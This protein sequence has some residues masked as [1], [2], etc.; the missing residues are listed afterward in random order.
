MAI[1]FYNAGDNAIYNSGSK[2][3]PQERF[4]LGYTAPATGAP[5]PTPAS[6]GIT[7][8]NAFNNSGG[9]G[10][11]LQVGDP[12]MNFKNYYNYTGDKYIKK[13]DTA[14]LDMNYDQKL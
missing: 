10:G 8:T 9:G 12:M 6:G 1:S 11:A 2:F 4:R 14:N 3:V 13:Q 7:N 5:V